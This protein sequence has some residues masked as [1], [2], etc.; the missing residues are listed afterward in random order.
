M[1]ISDIKI[2]A[3]V[4]IDL[5]DINGLAESMRD[6]GQLQPIAVQPCGLLIDGMRR[7]EAA[8]LLGWSDIAAHVVDVDELLLGERD[9]NTQRKNFTPTEAVAI[10]E[11]IAERHREL[12]ADRQHEQRVAAGIK[13]AELRGDSIPEAK[14][15]RGNEVPSSSG[16]KEPA[17]G[18]TKEV[19]ARAV[20]MS[21][22]SLYRATSVVKAAEA[23]PAR[24]GDLPARMDE[25]G[26][27][28]GTYQELERRKADAA[29]S[30]ESKPKP[31]HAIHGRAHHQR[32]DDEM[33]RAVVALEGICIALKDLDV[34]KLDPDR[35]PGW[36]MSLSDS[37]R[38]LSKLLRRIDGR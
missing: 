21:P 7:I 16:L 22:A 31:R 26:N 20:G 30:P 29:S 2:G 32:V 5:G 10:A 13:A 25:T 11:L 36:S 18:R 27:V 37:S 28:S 15:K 24:F 1:R 33:Q 19:V 34:K 3:R 6:R 35:V 17:A 23:D 8:K 4:R 9:A 12:I 14:T 38:F